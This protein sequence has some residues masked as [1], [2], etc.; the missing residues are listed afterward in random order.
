MLILAFDFI[1][2]RIF[3]GNPFNYLWVL[4]YSFKYSKYKKVKMYICIMGDFNG[5]QS[6]S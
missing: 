2:T 1:K 6:T 5:S 3:V 4:K